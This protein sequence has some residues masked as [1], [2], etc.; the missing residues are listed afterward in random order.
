MPSLVTFSTILVRESMK[1]TSDRDSDCVEAGCVN[2]LKVR[3]THPSV[4]MF[5]EDAWSRV[6]MVGC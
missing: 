4:P 1:L 2:R 5:F 6:G 3:Q